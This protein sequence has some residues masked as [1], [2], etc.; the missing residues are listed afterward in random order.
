M[1]EDNYKKVLAIEKLRRIRDHL[2]IREK[3]YFAEGEYPPAPMPFNE[4]DMLIHELE[5]EIQD[6]RESWL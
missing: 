2:N 5:G 3:W 6:S 4:I 1:K